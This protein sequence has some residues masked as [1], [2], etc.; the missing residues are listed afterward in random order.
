MNKL[1]KSVI[2]VLVMLVASVS[3]GKTIE[4]TEENSVVLN[5]AVSLKTV[6]KL[7]LEVFTK[8]LALS[9]TE[10]IYLV[11]DSPGG[12]VFAGESFIDSLRAIPN[13]IHTV[14]IFAASMAYQIVQSMDTRY[15]TDTSILMS[16]R[17]SGGARAAYMDEVENFISFINSI[18]FKMETR[19]AKRV[20]LTYKKYRELIYNEFWTTGQNAVTLKHADELV[21]V[22]CSKEMMTKTFMQTVRTFFGNV[23]LKFSKCPIIRY[24]VEVKFES[25]TPFETQTKIRNE[26]NEYFNNKYQYMKRLNKR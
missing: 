20:G 2:L 17:A 1:F 14:T 22:R 7:Q 5:E 12:S 19:S 11:L 16:H 23:K 15:V 26:L 8:S 4:L 6:S 18:I 24:P 13:P 10:P 21:S 25:D 9:P 3:F